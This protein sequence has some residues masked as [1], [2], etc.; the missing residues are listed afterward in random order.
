MPKLPSVEWPVEM[1]VVGGTGMTHAVVWD[2]PAS[3]QWHISVDSA[4][5]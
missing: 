5:A 3:W 4:Q 2:V 1:R